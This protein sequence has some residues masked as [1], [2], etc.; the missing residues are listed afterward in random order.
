MSLSR[1]LKQAE[2]WTRDIGGQIL[3]PA[4]VRDPII[5]HADAIKEA[6]ELIER[7]RKT[8]Q[9]YVT[10]EPPTGDGHDNRG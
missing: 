7:D 5:A 1:R 4:A 2:D 9:R 6:R 10:N 8:V 3:S